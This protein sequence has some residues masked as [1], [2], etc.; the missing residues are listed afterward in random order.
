MPPPRH[1]LSTANP[2]SYILSV[3]LNQNA[4]RFTQSNYSNAPISADADIYSHGNQ[5]LIGCHIP[6][7]PPIISLVDGKITALT[8]RTDLGGA[9]IER[10]LQYVTWLERY[11]ARDK[12]AGESRW[13]SISLIGR[14]VNKGSRDRRGSL[15]QRT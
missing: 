5:T 7:L 6:T 10:L 4:A 15:H 1:F 12:E 13:T 3:M 9:M 2:K 11:F 14:I 8:I